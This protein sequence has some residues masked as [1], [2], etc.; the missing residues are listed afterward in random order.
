MCILEAKEGG[1]R[2]TKLLVSNYI[3]NMATAVLGR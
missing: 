1:M 2:E 3:V